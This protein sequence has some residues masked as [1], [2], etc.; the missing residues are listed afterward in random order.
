MDHLRA[1]SAGELQAFF[2]KYYVPNNAIL[3]VAGKFDMEGTKDL[4]HKYY[5]WIPGK[6]AR[7]FTDKKGVIGEEKVPAQLVRDIPAEPEQTKARRAELR[8][9]VPLA[10]VMVAYPMPPYRSEDQ[11]ALSILS[12]IVG[13]GRSSRLSRLLVT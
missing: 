12:T 6:L 9:N 4:V 10:R 2:N 3:V 13:D 11:D 5:A 1:A 7:W 8:F